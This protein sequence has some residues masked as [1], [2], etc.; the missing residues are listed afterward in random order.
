MERERR[1]F[2]LDGPNGI[3]WIF[4][5]AISTDRE[6][7]MYVDYVKDF[8]DVSGGERLWISPADICHSRRSRLWP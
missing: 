3:D 6:Q 1:R 2:Y 5:R 7:A 8:T 4:P